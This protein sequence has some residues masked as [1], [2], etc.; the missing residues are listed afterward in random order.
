MP[1]KFKPNK[2]EQDQVSGKGS[3]WEDRPYY[4]R[5]SES[6]RDMFKKKRI[7]AEAA[8]MKD[9]SVRGLSEYNIRVAES[10]MRAINESKSKSNDIDSHI[11][12]INKGRIGI[13]DNAKKGKR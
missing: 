5:S 2:E 9:F 12:E 3:A 6:N 7:R 1:V 10:H 11:K 4:M 8:E 13:P